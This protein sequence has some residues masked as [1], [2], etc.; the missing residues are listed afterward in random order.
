MSLPSAPTLTA[1]ANIDGTIIIKWGDTIGATTHTVSIAP[2]AFIPQTVTG[3]TATFV[4]ATVQTQY[5]VS[6]YATNASGNSSTV[7][8]TVD[9]FKRGLIWWIDVGDS[10]TITFG[11]NRTVS[12]Y[13][14]PTVTKIADKSGTGTNGNK[15]AVIST[16]GSSTNIINGTAQTPVT[17]TTGPVYISSM[18]GAIVQDSGVLSYAGYVNTLI[19]TGGIDRPGLLFRGKSNT[20]TPSGYDSL[21]GYV[22]YNVYKNK[23]Q[24]IEFVKPLMK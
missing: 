3:K 1:A 7:T 8:R 15:D 6:I 20:G 19:P 18:T 11:P 23:D 13:S 17:T 14:F 4:G 2:G 9:D 10:S 5:T 12:G 16:T 24:I 22:G 21:Q